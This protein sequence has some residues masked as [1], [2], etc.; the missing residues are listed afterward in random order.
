[1][2]SVLSL[3]SGC[4]G[5]DHG[6]VHSG[7]QV[8]SA[9]DIDPIAVATYNRNLPAV[10][11]TTDLSSP[12]PLARTD[13]ILA[14][15]PCQG[16]SPIG[17]LRPDDKRNGLL[18]STCMMVARIQPK[19]FVLE[20]VPGLASGRNRA[21]LEQ[22]ISILTDAKYFVSTA[23]VRCEE[24]GLAQRRRRLFLI[25]RRGRA[26]FEIRLPS[27][28]RTTVR[29]VLSQLVPR[30]DDAPRHLKP[31]TKAYNI[32]KR[33]GPGQKLCNVRHSPA[34]VFTWDIPEAFG[35]VTSGQRRVLIALSRLRRSERARDFGDADAVTVRR[36]ETAVG[37]SVAADLEALVRKGYVRR[38]GSR[39][40]LAHTFNGTFRRLDYESVSPT[41]DTHFG[42]PRLFLHPTE[43]RGLSYREAAAL[44]GFQDDFVWPNSGQAR[45]QLIGNAVPPPVSLEVAQLVRGL[46]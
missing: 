22:A 11:Q 9:H 18:L 40:D 4:G 30:V 34:S 38:V 28:E 6:F 43:H 26:P 21:V 16:F 1:M 3:F 7:F 2:T 37:R 45:F 32:A 13:V 14:G 36:L 39:F 10:A 19:V 12:P 5:F 33:I 44:Q 17:S 23:T 15:P 24:L 8:D 35:K 46:L 31:G 42:E 20:N 29:E 25:A 27:R 41:V